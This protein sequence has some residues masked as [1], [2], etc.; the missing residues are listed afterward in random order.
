MSSSP[1]RPGSYAFGRFRLSADGTLLARDGAPV[2]LA[3]KVLQTL[4]ALVER[5]GQV[6]RKSDLLQAVWP[7]SFVE[8]T[9]LSRNISLL[10]RALADDHT[11]API[12]TVARVGYRFTAPVGWMDGRASDDPTATRERT[13]LLILPFRL[14]RD[15]PDTGFL[16]F[17]V[18]DAV[19]SVLSGLSSLAVR[20]S[21]VASRFAGESP[22]LARI[23]TEADVDTVAAGTLLRSGDQIRMAVQLLS[24]PSG[25]VLSTASVQVAVGET[26][27][28]Q[29]RLAAHIVESLSLSLTA[30]DRARLASDV[31]RSPAA[32][33]FFLRGN[34][35]VGAHAIANAANLR[36]ARELYR[37]SVEA[38][39][40]FAPGWARLGR[41]HYLIGKLD[42][43]GDAKTIASAEACFQQALALR[44]DLP[45]AHDLY[46]LLEID[47]GRP[48]AAMTRLIVRAVGG[49]VQAELYAALVQACRFAGLLEA[50][51]A[52]HRRARELDAKLPTG[53]YHTLWQLGEH[54]AALRESSRGPIIE[55]LLVGLR[56]D[57]GRAIQMLRQR[58]GGATGLLRSMLSSYRAVFEGNGE[59]ALESALPVFDAFP[60]PEAVFYV[61]RALAYF[62][63][64]RALA[65]F[66][67]S[68][69][70]GFTL[71]RLLVMPDPWLDPLRSR[72]AYAELVARAREEYTRNLSAYAEAGGERLLGPVPSADEVESQS[73]RCP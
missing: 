56:G 25:A 55:P 54:D 53:V 17:S 67:R 4:L 1:Q 40:R 5:H 26:L 51:L 15:D 29:D 14:L 11:P 68:L 16:A 58:E 37:Q 35:I 33:E 71:Y 43:A 24:A 42:Q 19:V 70:R 64:E 3:P 39:T 44:P 9:G 36:V 48:R 38:D 27:G 72:P 69:E 28:L 63:D 12:A 66:G 60:D 49:G 52:A 32:Y 20:S 47:Q 18:P 31:P 73:R 23:A 21:L 50:S 59:A 61:A 10:R 13:R 46:A 34:E 2:A 22:D 65:Q 30:L 8:E 6:V 41:C 57:K 45:L 7:D 62:S